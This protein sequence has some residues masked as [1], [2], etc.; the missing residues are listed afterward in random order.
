MEDPCLCRF[1]RATTTWKFTLMPNF[2]PGMTPEEFA[3]LKQDILE[4]GQL[5]PI[6][7]FQ[8]QILDGRHRWSVCQQLGLR[9]KYDTFKGSE[10]QALEYVISLNVKRRHLNESQRA[11]IAA[12][13]AT[14]RSG[15]RTD[16]APTGARSDAEAAELF[17]VGE[18]S[19]ERAKALKRE[20]PAEI[21]AEVMGGKQSHIWGLEGHSVDKGA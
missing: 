10:L 9:C 2:I 11:I 3:D 15:A 21:I 4:H 18:R 8:H 19:V 7:L 14:M 1:W 20:A 5:E 16:L 6:M 17:N 12:D 13:V